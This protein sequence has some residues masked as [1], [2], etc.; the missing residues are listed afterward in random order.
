MLPLGRLG[1]PIAVWQPGRKGCGV[2]GAPTHGSGQRRLARRNLLA[3]PLLHVAKPQALLGSLEQRAD[4]ASLPVVPCA[5]TNCAN[6]DDRQQQQQPQSLGALHS[7]N[8]I[9]DRLGICEVAAEGRIGHQQVIAHQPGDSLRLGRI[10]AEARGE[11]HRDVSAKHAVVAAATLGD[12]VE[13]H[14]DVE[15]PARSYLGENLSRQRMVLDQRPAFDLGK[16]A[17]GAD[18]MF[19]DGVVVVHVELHL[20]DDAAEVGDEAA[21]DAGFVHPAQDHVGAVAVGQCL[22]EEG[23]GGGIG[24]HFVGEAGVAGGCAH[25]RRVNLES[26]ARG[27]RE[28]LQQA[29]RLCGEKIVRRDRKSPAV[30]GEAVEIGCAPAE[31][32]QGETPTLAAELF[33][34]LGEEQSGQVADG[35]RVEKVELHEAFDRALAWAVGV[36]H[37]CG[38]LALAIEAEPFLG[39][40]RG[41]V[42]V[43]A[44]RPEEA[45]GALEPAIF[46]GG[47]QAS[48][49]QFGRLLHAVDIFAD[50]VER[51]KVAQA[52]LAVLDV[53][54]DDIAAVA[55]PLVALVALG[56]LGGDELARRTAHDL[57]AEPLASVDRQRLVAPEIAR[58]KQRGADRHVRPGKRDRLVR[59]ADRLA[60]LQ[61]EIPQQI[62]ERFA[63]LLAPRR[64][65]GGH[66]HHQVEVTE[67][68]HLAAPRAAKPDQ[69]H[70][71]GRRR[72]GVGIK[73]LGDEIEAEPDDLIDK[74]SIGR[75][76]GA[77]AAGL[78]GE[79]RG[80]LGAAGGE[81]VA[82]DG[83]DCGLEVGPVGHARY[84]I[85]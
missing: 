59:G 8:E 68:R 60:D 29:G 21:E 47:Q 37:R 49:N 3:S 31:G 19:V 14:S 13:Q 36:A 30:E 77:A 20:R 7:V 62:E 1:H 6:V 80:N 26:M 50:P 55:H 18:R 76:M 78:S 17:D 51:V 11:L 32:R 69:R 83:G 82:K 38:N 48:A 45:L 71:F 24:A 9:L 79:P 42:K 15:H 25:R 16:Q 41:E 84:G 65:A 61:L 22:D 74:E 5:R 56:E 67:R 52:A 27:K 66:Q 28:Q 39:P 75:G 70:A 64:A 63:D 4:Q 2:R 85:R 44:H 43:A 10:E 12:I 35:L 46:L 58:F 33:V 34:E 23:I 54:L 72:I 53:G 73:P 81:G 57:G 40:A